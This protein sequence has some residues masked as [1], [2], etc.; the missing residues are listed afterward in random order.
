MAKMHTFCNWEF[1][2]IYQYY[3]SGQFGQVKM[4]R[5]MTVLTGLYKSA[6][7]PKTWKT[8]KICVPTTSVPPITTV[9]P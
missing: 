2:K 7:Q 3:R 6:N 1:K 4:A 9:L 8:L 5:K